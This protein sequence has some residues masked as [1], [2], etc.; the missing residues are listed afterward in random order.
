MIRMNFEA[1]ELVKFTE[2]AKLIGE[3]WSAALAY[4]HCVQLTHTDG[5]KIAVY[6]FD[7]GGERYDVRG[8]LPDVNAW[9][10]RDEQAAGLTANSEITTAAS[11]SA[12]AIAGEI[13]RRLLV[14]Y[15]PSYLVIKGRVDAN[16]DALA[17][18]ADALAALVA[19][20]PDVAKIATDRGGDPVE[21][22]TGYHYSA[23]YGDFKASTWQGHI[24]YAVKLENVTPELAAQ[25]LALVAQT[26]I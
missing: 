10:S 4:E 17:R 15:D 22:S 2:V 7:K 26:R 8:V 3:G 13:T 1:G 21:V 11:K 20:A 23:P 25:I 5:R 19:V 16:N 24:T 14:T 6:R 18:K 12:K 9:F